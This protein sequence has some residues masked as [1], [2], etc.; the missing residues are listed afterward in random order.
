MVC[1][2]STIA[3]HLPGRTDNEI[4][5]YWNTHLKKRLLQLGIDPVT[6]K[7]CSSTDL[8]VLETRSAEM[9][10]LSATQS[11]M[12]QWDRV[13][14]ETEARLSSTTFFPKP[15]DDTITPLSAPS[16]AEAFLNSWK[17]A[18]IADSRQAMLHS[19][20]IAAGVGAAAPGIQFSEYGQS[21]G[22]FGLKSSSQYD[23][24]SL[25]TFWNAVPT[26]VE[27]ES[28]S[29]SGSQDDHHRHSPG[30]SSSSRDSH[31]KLRGN[32]MSPTSILSEPLHVPTS[33]DLVWACNQESANFWH[34]Q[35]QVNLL[36]HN[37]LSHVET[38]SLPE[39]ISSYDL[40]QAE[41]CHNFYNFADFG[42]QTYS[43]PAHR[44][45]QTATRLQQPI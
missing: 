43:Q 34:N 16:D 42:P 6:H 23:S 31:A 32:P 28:S 40:L 8:E 36:T 9:N 29:T 15:M 30:S 27:A 26:I 39:T 1:R 12:S 44:V 20:S 25:G 33:G 21:G 5:N 37:M 3:A 45:P 2:W 22:V 17:A 41:N 35:M 13:R 38:S 18:R 7:P 19:E 11:H 24:V 10:F 4:K 14:M